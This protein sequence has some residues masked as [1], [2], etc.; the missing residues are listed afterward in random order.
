MDDRLKDHDISLIVM[1]RLRTKP[2]VKTDSQTS[3]V[4]E[5]IYLVMRFFGPRLKWRPTSSGIIIP[6]HHHID[7]VREDT[8]GVIEGVYSGIDAFGRTMQYELKGAI[9]I[10]IA[11]GTEE[12]ALACLGKQRI[13]Y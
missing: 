6:S 7:Q 3:P 4:F 5:H 12:N 8:N 1:P 10:V 9:D 11:R 13:S 2:G